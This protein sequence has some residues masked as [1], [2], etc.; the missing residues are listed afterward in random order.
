MKAKNIFV[1]SM[2]FVATLWYA[3]ADNH[4]H[5][6]VETTMMESN[7]IVD[8][9]VWNEDFS[10]LVTAV[11]EAGL[12]DTLA[13]EGPFTVFAPLNS[14][15]AALPEGTVETL[16]MPEN[17]ELL[18]GVLTYHVLAWDVRA[19]ALQRGLS[20]ATVEGSEVRFEMSEGKWYINGAEI[21]ATDIIADNGVIHVIDSVILPPAD[22][23]TME[24]QKEMLED[25]LT[26]DEMLRI[27]N[28][29]RGLQNLLAGRNI[30]A[31]NILINRVLSTIDIALSAKNLNESQ[32]N[33][34]NYLQLHIMMM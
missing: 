1:A 25:I 8:I 16:L 21:V 22:M 26:E 13:S 15:F 24:I 28:F 33:I 32:T 30:N 3:G 18:Q 7:T 6:D 11:V 12:A 5:M 17:L 4:G 31:Q 23:M 27:T 34:L 19:S 2:L 29:D 10:T 9:A 14:A 20:I